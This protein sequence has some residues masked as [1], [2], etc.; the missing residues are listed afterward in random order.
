M[1]SFTPSGA[2][3]RCSWVNIFTSVLI[4]ASPAFSLVRIRASRERDQLR[5]NFLATFFVGVLRHLCDLDAPQN[6]LDALIHLA[7]R[8]ANRATLSLIALP[9]HRD[10]RGDE[11]RAI[12]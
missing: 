2:W 1:G 6:L 5:Q 3:V 10:A 11:Q 4:I 7:Q 8:L 9:A 12:D